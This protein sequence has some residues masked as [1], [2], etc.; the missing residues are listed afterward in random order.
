MRQVFRCKHGNEPRNEPSRLFV[1]YY[2][3]KNQKKAAALLD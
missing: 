2:V 3:V 1:V